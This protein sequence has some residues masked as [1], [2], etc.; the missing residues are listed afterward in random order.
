MSASYWEERFASWA[1]PPGKSEADRI[2]SAVSAIK[3]AMEADDKLAQITKVYVQGSYRNRVNVRQESDVDIGVL[4]TGGG[5]YP[6]F[7][8]G[9]TRENFG[10]EEHPY[11]YSQFKEDIQTALLN[12][13]GGSGV[14]RG[15]KA[16][17]IR[18]NSYRVD[19]DVVPVFEH[20]RYSP[21]GS[22]HSG[23]QLFPDV[24]ERIVNWPEQLLGD[25][26]RQHYEEAIAKNDA[27]KRAF[28]GVVRILKK[29]R[30]VMEDAGFQSAKVV[31]GFLIEC[32]V[33]NVPNEKFLYATWDEVV[34]RVITY[35]WVSTKTADK[36]NNWV[37]VSGWK[38]LF[39]GSPDSKRAA[40]YK[41]IDEAWSYIGVRKY[42]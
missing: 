16:F 12:R 15:K 29:L 30:V 9:F 36:C 1:G 23:V 42:E 19:A 39:R 22:F 25:W 18:P 37:E 34:T 27:T 26:P 32:L 17:D 4:Y 7:P 8:E 2:E 3:K 11:T 20:R 13:F 6:D 28:K 31:P 14:H 24:G 35:I 38:Y 40:A 33:Y 10:L 41:F 21:D 5:C